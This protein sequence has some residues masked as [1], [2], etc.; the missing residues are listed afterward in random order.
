MPTFDKLMQ[1]VL[2]AR[3]SGVPEGD[4][5]ASLRR[6][7]MR[8]RDANQRGALMNAALSSR[9]VTSANQAGLIQTAGL[10]GQAY[11]PRTGAGA[12]IGRGF[13]EAG[14]AEGQY[15]RDLS[16][17]ERDEQ[18]RQDRLAKEEAD[19]VLKEK[20]IES[21]KKEEKKQGE[22]DLAL[23]EKVSKVG[24]EAI[25]YVNAAA[26]ALQIAQ[27]TAYS[28][29]TTAAITAAMAAGA[30]VAE[31]NVLREQFVVPALRAA[32]KSGEITQ[33]SFDAYSLLVSA[34][35]NLTTVALKAQGPGPKTDFDFIVAA[36]ET[37]NLEKGN[38]S[39]I[40][41]QLQRLVFNA[42]AEISALGK[43]PPKWTGER[44]FSA[45]IPSEQESKPA[46][47]KGS[48]DFSG[49]YNWKP[50]APTPSP[51][52]TPTPEPEEDGGW[53]NNWWGN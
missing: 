53:F 48:E 26:P 50:V 12:A 46:A 13:A 20:D 23:Y 30:S 44:T 34:V 1:K 51:T 52:P 32:V 24:Q 21:K 22:K 25:S 36:R 45:S 10:Q 41:S 2:Q 39:T 27:D 8:T 19:R 5:T 16:R 42:N 4:I 14:E 37:A 33:E 7:A 47:D 15:Q 29:T 18:V 31:I 3:Q 49:K 28:G 11:Q 35:T 17:I 40:R 6:N 43:T 38:P 9:D